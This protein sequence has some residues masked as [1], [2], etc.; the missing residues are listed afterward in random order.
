V[1]VAGMWAAE[2]SAEEDGLRDSEAGAILAHSPLAQV[3]P[4]DPTNELS[5]NALAIEFGEQLFFDQRLARHRNK[6]C[7]TC[8]NPS[9]NWSSPNPILSPQG[10]PRK[11]PSLMNVAWN[12][13]FFWDGRADSLWA[14]ATGP[15]E[16]EAELGMSRIDLVNLIAENKDWLDRYRD[17]F[18]DPSALEIF[19]GPDQSRQA[20]STI[21]GSPTRVLVNIA[22][23]LAAY[24]ETLTSGPAPFDRF[25]EGVRT[26]NEVLQTA[27]SAKA[28][29]GAVLFVGKARCDLC[30]TGPTFSDGEFHDVFVLPRDGSPQRDPGRYEGIPAL[31][32]SEFRGDGEFSSIVGSKSKRKLAFLKRGPENW[33]QFKTPSLRNVAKNPSFMHDGQFTSLRDVITNYINIGKDDRAHVHTDRFLLGNNLNDD[34]IE[35][36]VEF[37]ESLSGKL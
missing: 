30:H 34:E 11:V 4:L 18:E 17:L 13:W 31:L 12:R 27:I 35:A 16:G 10:F 25:V 33:G 8:H 9:M 20:N 6:S 29:A 23:C 19:R 3:A 5:G 21:T 1:F 28:K 7:A 26:K 14:Q 36:L 22:K 32:S 2:A 37:L 15:I 24:M